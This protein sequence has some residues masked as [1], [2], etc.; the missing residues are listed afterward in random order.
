MS[1]VVT[2]GADADKAIAAGLQP[3]TE[4]DT[5][6]AWKVLGITRQTSWLWRTGRQEVPLTARFAAA[7]HLSRV[8]G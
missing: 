3:A 2:Y 4:A 7:W 5:A 8:R 6:D 1:R